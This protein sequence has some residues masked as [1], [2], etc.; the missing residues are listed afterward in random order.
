MFIIIAFIK[1]FKNV[2]LDIFFEH[3]GHDHKFET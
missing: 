3:F 2:T 1:H